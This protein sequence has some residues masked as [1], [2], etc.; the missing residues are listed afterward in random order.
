MIIH[1]AYTISAVVTFFFLQMQYFISQ[2]QIFPVNMVSRLECMCCSFYLQPWCSNIVEQL[3]I[4]QFFVRVLCLD[5]IAQLMSHVLRLV[6]KSLWLLA[7]KAFFS[8]VST[9]M[10]SLF[11]MWRDKNVLSY[12]E[13]ASKL[14]R[15]LCV[16]SLTSWRI[17]HCSLSLIF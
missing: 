8:P 15:F 16:Y 14:C 7:E 11:W 6:T 5:V 13:S 10:F 2:L 4:L 9:N 12:L 17:A 1:C 3:W